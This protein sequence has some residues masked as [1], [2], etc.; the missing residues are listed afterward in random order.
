MTEATIKLHVGGERIVA[1]AEGNGP[2]NAL[3]KALRLAIA[4]STRT[5]PTSS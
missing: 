1:T 5:W 4:R 3:D 2:V